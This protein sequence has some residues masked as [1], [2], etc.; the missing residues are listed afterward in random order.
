MMASSGSSA[1]S[2]PGKVLRVGPFELQR[3]VEDGPS[4]DDPVPGS[5][6]AISPLVA[7]AHSSQPLPDVAWNF[8]MVPRGR[9]CWPMN[10]VMSLI[11]SAGGMQVPAR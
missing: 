4:G 7:R 5:K 8:S 3:L 6:P 1:G 11:G 2:R 10:R 9:A